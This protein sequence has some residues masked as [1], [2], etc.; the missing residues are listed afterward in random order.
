MRKIILNSHSYSIDRMKEAALE[1]MRAMGLVHCVSLLPAKDA[2]R[3]AWSA[4]KQKRHA[5]AVAKRMRKYTI[6]ER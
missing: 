4:Y 5:K 6:A 1:E 3:D 2:P